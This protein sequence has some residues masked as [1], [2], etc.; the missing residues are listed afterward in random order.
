MSRRI[1]LGYQLLIGLSDTSTG[2][3]LLVAPELT[4]RMMRLHVPSDALPYISFIGAFVFSVGI[5]CLYGAFVIASH[6]GNSKLEVVWLLTTFTRGSV[7]IFVVAQV[8][9]GTLESGWVT[10]AAADG[11]CVLVQ[12]IGLRQGWAAHVAR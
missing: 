3:L 10:V 7:A 2:A 5:A 8:L 9:A 6:G 12:V 1:L 4:L 11:F